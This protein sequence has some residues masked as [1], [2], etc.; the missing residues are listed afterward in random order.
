M[1][2]WKLSKIIK[3]YKGDGGGTQQITTQN[4]P[5][6]F[7]PAIRNVQKFATEEYASGNLSKVAGQSDLQKKSFGSAVPGLEEI[8]AGNR[9]TLEEQRSRLTDMA[10]TGGADELRDALALDI[11]MGNATIGN[12]YGG[13]G[14]LGSYRQNLASATSED[15]AKAKFAQQVIANKAAAE[16]GLNTNAS[17]MSADQS[18]LIKT[19]ESSGGQQRSI[20]QQQLD[21]AYQGLQRYASTIYGNPARQSTQVVQSGGGK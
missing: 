10:T 14:T 3:H 12:Q 4:I 16:A 8:V 13:A 5:E 19:L 17:S 18:N 7:R 2:K 9:G 15:A 20:D 11:G 1:N 6:E 21:A